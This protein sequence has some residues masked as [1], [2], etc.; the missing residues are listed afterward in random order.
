MIRNSILRNSLFLTVLVLL[1]CSKRPREN[2][3]FYLSL[4]TDPTGLHPVNNATDGYASVIGGYVFESLLS[5]DDDYNWEPALATDW[6]ISSDKK[7]FTFTLREG[8]KWSDGRP[9]TA[10]DVVFS[11][12]V[13]FDENYQ[14]A[15][16]RSYL[17][18]IDRVEKVDHKTVK[19]I[20]KE[21]L[22]LNF[23]VA[24]GLDILPK[25]FYEQKGKSKGYFVKNIIGTGPYLLKEYERGKRILLEQNPLWWGRDLQKQKERPEYNFPKLSFKVVGDSTVGL[26]RL[27]KGTLDYY[28][29]QPVEYVKKTSGG[30]WEKSVFK[31]LCKNKSPK[32]YNWIG[33]NLKH[34]ILKSRNVRLALFKLVNRKLMVEKFEYGYSVPAKGPIYPQSPYHDQSI[35]VVDFDPKGALQL[36]RSEG[37]SDTNNDQILD[38]VI[39]GKRMDFTITILEPYPP[40]MKYLSVFKE[41]AKK[42][43]VNIEIK[44]IEWNSFVQ[45]MDEKKFDAIRLTW[46]ASVDWDPTQ[47]WHTNS[48]KG[49]SNFISYSN[50]EVDRLS[51]LAR[52]TFDKEKRIQLLQK[53]EKLIVNDYPY[54]WFTYK[55]TTMYAY[56][57]R[58]KRPQDC[59]NYSVGTSFWSFKRRFND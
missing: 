9:L 55:D 29:L 24:A 22:H 50:T 47:I 16:V 23:N 54:V 37:W 19:F 11:F 56:N 17:S 1:S 32:G 34:P 27:K 39:G 52:K 7:V 21:A 28:S 15:A 12:D 20:A 57:E 4:P 26:E 40:F 33:W 18:G 43:G 46:T 13:F 35:E 6:K 45:L 58:I 49:G 3:V 38:K 2:S 8:V 31:V 10:E 14:G 41:D 42:V 44:Q 59:L 5:R 36:L 48:I 25:H 51:E 53:A 30:E